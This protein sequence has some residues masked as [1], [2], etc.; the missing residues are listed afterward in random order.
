MLFLADEKEKLFTTGTF[1]SL[2]L[3][4]ALSIHF[5]YIGGYALI[6]SLLNVL[7][8]ILIFAGYKSGYALGR[9]V[10]MTLAVLCVGG[11][12]NSFAYEDA[13]FAK[14]PLVYIVV[15]ALF[16]GALFMLLFHS[17]GQHMRLRKSN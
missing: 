6:L 4:V 14:V 7:V 13:E 1:V 11:Q 15:D 2:C 12:L 5:A 8:P 10:L 16:S 9:V 3:F 17:L